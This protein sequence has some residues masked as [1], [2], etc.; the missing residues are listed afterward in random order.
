MKYFEF[1][2]EAIVFTENDSNLG[3]LSGL[4]ERFLSL[5]TNELGGDQPQMFE[6][7]SKIIGIW[8][9]FL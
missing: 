5:S 9:F 1:L 7:V 2:T 3:L 4:V 8:S 6:Y